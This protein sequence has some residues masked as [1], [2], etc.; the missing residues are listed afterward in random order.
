MQQP[1]DEREED[2]EQAAGNLLYLAASE[3]GEEGQKLSK[4]SGMSFLLI[5]AGVH[6]LAITYSIPRTPKHDIRLK[7]RFLSLF[8]LLTSILPLYC[9]T[10]NT[11]H[12]T[13][14]TADP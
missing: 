2:E 4:V 10:L 8:S 3:E 5:L 9:A 11:S 13:P 14:H 6:T 7:V 1:L 12:P